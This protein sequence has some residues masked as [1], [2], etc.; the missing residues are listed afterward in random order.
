[1]ATAS[2]GQADFASTHDVFGIKLL[3]FAA[4]QGRNT[5][6]S[7]NCV[8]YALAGLYPASTGDTKRE[9]ARATGMRESTSL[10][11]LLPVFK[12]QSGP[13][14]QRE[15]A[16]AAWVDDSIQ[17]SQAYIDS[18]ASD[19]DYRVTNL[20]L[21]APRSIQMINAWVREKTNG[22]IPLILNQMPR[23]AVLVLTSGLYVKSSWK[24]TMRL[25]DKPLMFTVFG[26]RQPAKGMTATTSLARL[27]TA[28]FDAV[29]VPLDGGL[30]AEIYLPKG[31]AP[32]E[33]VADG[34][35]TSKP[36]F[37][38]GTVPTMLQM[39]YWKAEYFA[40]IVEPLRKSGLATIFQP[41]GELAAIHPSA[42]VIEVM[43]RTWT[44]FNDRGIEAAAATALVV[45]GLGGGEGRPKN[46]KPFI[47]DRPFFYVLRDTTTGAALF[48]GFIYEPAKYQ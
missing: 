25:M 38:T 17:P 22:K 45:G 1:M 42:F 3:R 36:R 48:M 10:T 28:A 24:P 43:H 30:A 37:P 6:V 15:S 34:L 31:G 8:L 26:S 12:G 47:V 2:V 39:P 40:S 19:L 32:P 33:L 44:E 21:Q 5:V 11:E 7:P 4:V 9:L 27:E 41:R 46:P 20:D 13:R 14:W 18:M 23:Q 16:A 35:I 29:S